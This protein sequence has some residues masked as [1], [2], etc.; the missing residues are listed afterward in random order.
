MAAR[1]TA[2]GVL[3]VLK[4][5]DPGFEKAFAKLERRREADAEDVERSA[6]KIVDRVRAGGDKDAL[7]VLAD[8]AA[9]AVDRMLREEATLR[10]LSSS[11]QELAVVRRAVRKQRTK[12]LGK[13]AVMREPSG[14]RGSRALPAT[15]A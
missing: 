8:Q 13:S 1:S 11:K 12:M 14:V 4:S 7:E 15:P 2:K 5:D 3:P 6:R 10:E 9:I